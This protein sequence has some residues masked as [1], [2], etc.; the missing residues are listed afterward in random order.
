[1]DQLDSIDTDTIITDVRYRNEAEAILGL[2]KLKH[3]KAL[4]IRVNRSYGNTP[5]YTHPSET[6]L[7]DYDWGSEYKFVIAN[8][9][10]LDDL[11]KKVT[12]FVNANILN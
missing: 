8:D 9:G 2:N 10:T 7:D 5:I 12:N 11:K 4:L 3:V 6:D 1:L